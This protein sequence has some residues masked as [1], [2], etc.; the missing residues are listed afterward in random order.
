MP[1]VLSTKKLSN[2][3]KEL[4]LNTGISLVEY[5]AIRLQIEDFEPPSGKIENAIFT[6]KNAVRAVLKKKLQIENCFCVG[7]KTADFLKENGFEVK[8]TADYAADLAKLILEKYSDKSFTFFCGNK[9]RDEL[10]E[11]LTKNEINFHEIQVYRTSLNF[12]EFQQNFDGI[13]FFSPSAVISFTKK[14]KI[15][16]AIAFSIGNTTASEAMKHTKNIIIANSPGI[17]NVIARAAKFFKNQ[18]AE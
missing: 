3:Q 8:E 16:D 15:G 5:D 13:F 6:S 12:Q 17:E 4:L 18:Q 10:P 9:R 7:S 14:N 1:R 2:N 11:I